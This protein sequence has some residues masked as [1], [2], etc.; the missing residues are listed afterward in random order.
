MYASE[1]TNTYSPLGY[2]KT[3]MTSSLPTNLDKVAFEKIGNNSKKKSNGT[4]LPPASPRHDLNQESE[5]S[6]WID[7]LSRSNPVL[8]SPAPSK[9]RGGGKTMT[10]EMSK[11]LSRQ[12]SMSHPDAPKSPKLYRQCSQHSTGLGNTQH[13]GA[14]MNVS[15]GTKSS[16]GRAQSLQRGRSRGRSQSR[17]RS[18]DRSASSR[19]SHSRGRSLER[20]PKILSQDSMHRSSFQR[21]HSCGADRMSQGPTLSSHM[22]RSRSV[23]RT[24]SGSGSVFLDGNAS[25]VSIATINGKKTVVLTPVT[26]EQA[27]QQ[28][29]R[30]RRRGL[31]RFIPKEV[32]E[33]PP[34]SLLIIWT[35]VAIELAFDLATTIIAFNSFLAEGSCCGNAIQLGNLP[36]ASTVPFFMLIVTELAFLSRAIALTLWPSLMKDNEDNEIIDSD[37]KRRQRSCFRRY[38]CCFF[39]FK[40]Q[41][42]LQ[43]LNLMVLLN[44]FLGCI[45]AWILM[46][47][48]DEN[49]AFIVLGMEGASLILHFISVKLEGGL[50]TWKQIAFHSIPLIPFLFS[51]GLVL[52]Y[53]K[54]GGVCYLV[55]EKL[56]KFTGCEICNINGVSMPCPNAT[57]IFGDFTNNLDSFDE[58]KDSFTSRS[59]Q[60]TYCATGPEER[61]FCFYDYNGGQSEPV[62]KEEW[63]ASLT[64]MPTALVPTLAITSAPAASPEGED[65]PTGSDTD[66]TFIPVDPTLPPAEST[67]L[68]VEPT[69]PPVETIALPT[70]MP[71]SPIP[72]PTFP[73]TSSV[74]SRPVSAPVMESTEEDSGDGGGG[75]DGFNMDDVGSD[76]FNPED[77]FR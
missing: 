16:R 25:V 19:P 46:Y 53:L 71:V 26:F 45:I 3:K 22:A 14:S 56:F 28:G 67:L 12:A 10:R 55:D 33:K 18:I 29:M 34:R 48:S 60:G 44:P 1:P 41:V 70:M 74:T 54:Q 47:Q 42:L 49:G 15:N 40:I 5:N 9:G 6:M 37:G 50:K 27:G 75:S 24:R 23:S 20:N 62:N 8:V 36:L 76:G 7:E 17:D 59:I 66:S 69:L 4:F 68:P 21:S 31:R 57:G 73:P 38:I 72:L 30:G 43:F 65:V 13:T 64:S 2:S 51:V 35:I 77:L 58:V 52:F 32:E 11:Q 61:S 63:T 39:R